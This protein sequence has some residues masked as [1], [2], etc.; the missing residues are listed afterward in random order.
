M[1]QHI[2]INSLKREQKIQTKDIF[3][4]GTQLAI[5]EDNHT[6]A[7]EIKITCSWQE[8]IFE[9]Q[10]PGLQEKVK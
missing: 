2:Q 8:K 7:L 6:E 10:F 9:F 5:A 3:N 1:C 4:G